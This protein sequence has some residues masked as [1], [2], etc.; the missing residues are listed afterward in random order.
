MNIA[1]ILAGGSGIRVE[2]SLPKQFFKVAG[3]MVIE[4]AVAAF[5][6]NELI[7]EIAI[8]INNH[9][10]FLVEDMII[11]NGWKKVKRVLIGGKERYHSSLAAINAYH[12]SKDANLIFHDA[13][14]P[15]VSQRIIDDVVKAL[16]HYK[17]VDVAINS[18][19]TI[20][21]VQDDL[22]TA[23]PERIKMLKGQTPQGFKQEVIAHAYQL[24]LQ[25]ENF[26]ATDDC[27][28]VK[29]YLPEENIYVV[30]GEEVNMKLTYPEDTYL[31]DKL[32]QLRS[33]EI[34]D[35]ELSE[36][37]LENKVMV[38]FGGGYG[39][40]KSIVDLAKLN[41]IRVYSFSR[42]ENN[43]DVS[44]IKS[45]TDAIEKVFQVEQK[46]DFI[47]NTAGILYKE[48][49]ETMNYDNVLDSIHTNY[50]GMVNIALA[51]LPYLKKSKGHI[52]FF[53]S[54]SYTRGRAFYS[55]YSST[56]AAIVNF[57]QAISQE[58][59][60][61][62]IKVNCINPERTLTPMRI[63]NFGNEPESTLLK[64]ETVALRTIQ[65][66]LSNYTGQVIDV[67]L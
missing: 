26:R 20:I 10:L 1:V 65:V 3:K 18:A 14:R 47:I 25:D 66:L 67:R 35:I 58:W 6:K 5:E 24:A 2:K 28:V 23:I 11:K 31:L 46:I 51:S 48:P 41:G 9:Y 54:S 21:E 56:K 45:V 63:K 30:N 50:L 40:G 16:D 22:I 60:T 39:I 62:G 8:V 64:P 27:G 12:D 53:T 57:A 17:A 49:L 13:A 19:D 15:L 33:V 37:A 36:K 7:D 43:V 34:Q 44:N 42:S 32:F 38:V 52:L 61:F 29:K 59:E 55:I 4:H